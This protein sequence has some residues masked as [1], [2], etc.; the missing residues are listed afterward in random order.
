MP[1]NPTHNPIEQENAQDPEIITPTRAEF[2][3]KNLDGAYLKK[4]YLVGLQL[5][6]E[7]GCEIDD[8]FFE[9]FISNAIA[10]VE[11]MANIDILS[12]DIKNEAH[13]YRVEDYIHYGFLQLYRIPLQKVSEVRAEYPTGQTIQIFPTE[14]FV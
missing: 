3:L 2:D 1:H 6:G 8:S 11:D 9:E 12:R 10:R 13:D 5:K 14:G 7:D 4:I